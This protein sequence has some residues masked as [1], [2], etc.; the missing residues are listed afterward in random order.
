MNWLSRFGSILV[1]AV[2][3]V[4]SAFSPS[5]PVDAAC[6]NGSTT[7]CNPAGSTLN[8][9]AAFVDP[10]PPVGYTQCAGFINTPLDDV[11]FNWEN[12][13]IPFKTSDLYLRVFDDTTGQILAGAR[14][15]T[16]TPLD[17]APTTGLNYRADQF[18]G[19]RPFRHPNPFLG[20]S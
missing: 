15:H 2:V 1:F 19:R 9:A 20:L 8:P 7:D 10:A 5:R 12:N 11:A 13:C 18:E 14:L 4:G 6:T 17:F 3:M 16:P